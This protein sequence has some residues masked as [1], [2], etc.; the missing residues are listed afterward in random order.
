[1]TGVAGQ[2]DPLGGSPV[3]RTLQG[4]AAAAGLPAGVLV[5]L[6]IG[7]ETRH[8]GHARRMVRRHLIL[9]PRVRVSAPR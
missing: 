8:S 1:V 4:G 3:G 2:A 7:P 5:A 6:L 9:A